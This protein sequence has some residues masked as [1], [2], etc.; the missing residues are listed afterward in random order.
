MYRFLYTE[1]LLV[2]DFGFTHKLYCYPRL[3]PSGAVT[4]Y[5]RY[6]LDELG[7]GRSGKVVP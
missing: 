6:E 1:I 3:D 2:Q 5:V 4:R 7:T